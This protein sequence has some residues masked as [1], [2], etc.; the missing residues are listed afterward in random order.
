MLARTT[1]TDAGAAARNAAAH[2]ELAAD[3]ATDADAAELAFDH[4][5]DGAGEVGDGEFGGVL[6]RTRVFE[7]VHAAARLA[8][9]GPAP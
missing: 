1:P 4:A 8:L 3:L 6:A 7:E 9:A 2:A 5:A